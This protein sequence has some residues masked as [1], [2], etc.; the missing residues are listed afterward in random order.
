MF[1]KLHMKESIILRCLTIGDIVKVIVTDIDD[2]G[3]SIF[4]E[5]S[6]YLNHKLENKEYKD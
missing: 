4:L 2:R 3:R 1:Q 5:K 6:Y